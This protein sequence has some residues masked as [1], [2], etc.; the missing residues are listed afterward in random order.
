MNIGITV[1]NPAI[2]IANSEAAIGVTV[3]NP[4]IG[5]TL[6]PSQGL[7]GP[8][9]AAGANGLNGQDGADGADAASIYAFDGTV[10]FDGRNQIDAIP[11]DIQMLTS[12]YVIGLTVKLDDQRTA[13]S[14]LFKP[15]KDG[16]A[17]AATNLD[18]SI[19]GSY[20]LDNYI[21]HDT[22]DAN[23]AFSAGDKLGLKVVSTG[24]AP[25]ANTARFSLIF[26]A[27]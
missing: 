11:F 14:I 24:F 16:T 7:P 19:N 1:A 12:G 15:A 6:T 5:L 8:P 4:A 20:P 2:G 21:N 26:K 13:G 10:F 9:G 27:S 3:A 23:F 25:L 18:C 22:D 17:I